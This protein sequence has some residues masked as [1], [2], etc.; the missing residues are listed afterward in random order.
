MS[1]PKKYIRKSKQKRGAT[2]FDALGF[3]RVAANH[4]GTQQSVVQRT[5]NAIIG[6]NFTGNARGDYALDFQVLRFNDDDVA[7]GKY[8]MV[9]GVAGR[10]SGEGS[11]AIGNGVSA[12][13]LYGFAAGV[14]S[15][16]NG[17]RSIALGFGADAEDDDEAVIACAV[18]RV[19]FPDDS[20]HDVLYNGY[21]P[22]EIDGIADEAQL[23]VRAYST[24]TKDIQQ[25]QDSSGNVLARVLWDGSYQ[26]GSSGARLLMTLNTDSLGI[27]PYNF[28]ADFVAVG[29]AGA[30]VFRAQGAKYLPNSDTTNIYYLFD[31]AGVLSPD[32]TSLGMY[33]FRS[34][35]KMNAGGRALALVGANYEVYSQ[36]GGQ[37][38]EANGLVVYIDAKN[39][40]TILSSK[41]IVI[42]TFDKQAGSVLTD[43]YGI[44]IADQVNATNNYALYTNAGKV[45]FGD[46]VDVASGKVLKINATQVVSARQTGWSAWTGTAT[47]SS[48][49]TSTTTLA[50][51][52]EALKALIDDLTA[53]GLIGA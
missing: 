11:V 16:A 35:V 3:V 36:G 45:H 52:A 22:V 32:H 20:K 19:Q 31:T 27:Q 49:A 51:V 46:D 9:L 39:G 44:Y 14:G 25:W 6:G 13:A 41:G 8:S 37:V 42:Q 10:A 34:I 33:G 38:D 15:Q 43:A 24:Q 40:S 1:V 4:I 50:N 53:H 5:N 7:S 28:D 23:I 17:P 48:K 26:L 18:L 21:A 29:F 2:Q 12:D 30:G 47:R